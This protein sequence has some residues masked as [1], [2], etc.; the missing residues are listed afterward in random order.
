MRRAGANIQDC[1][2]GQPAASPSS[3]RSLEALVENLGDPSSPSAGA[4]G[5]G[6]LPWL[7]VKGAQGTEA[8][9]T[10]K[11]TCLDATRLQI[12]SGGVQP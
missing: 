8:A 6:P 3:Q 4:Q 9:A 12:R 10:V 1:P 5:R 7:P 2:R 11:Y